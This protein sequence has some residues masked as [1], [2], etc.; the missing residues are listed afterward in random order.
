MCPSSGFRKAAHM[1]LGLT[2]IEGRRS[3]PNTN[4]ATGTPNVSIIK[5]NNDARLV[6]ELT[7]GA[8]TGALPFCGA[9]VL[10]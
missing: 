1:T 6:A 8:P 10:M 3:C 9:R 7:S 4:K 2:T 5:V